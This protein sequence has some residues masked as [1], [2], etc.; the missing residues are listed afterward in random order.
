MSKKIGAGSDREIWQAARRIDQRFSMQSLQSLRDSTGPPANVRKSSALV[1]GDE[2][3]LWQGI[4]E[5]VLCRSV[6][7]VRIE[8]I[9]YM[10]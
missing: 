3:E 7:R 10:G 5:A 2:V 8:V 9:S 4:E 1:V 6:R